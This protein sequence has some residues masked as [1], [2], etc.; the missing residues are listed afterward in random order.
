MMIL[1]LLTPMRNLI[2]TFVFWQ[3]LKIRYMASPY[4]RAAFGNVDD[5]I[6]SLTSHARCPGMIG[7]GY[8]K[9]RSF[10]QKQGQMPT[11]GE[12]S[13]RPKCVVM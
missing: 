2:S 12:A 7:A 13:A 4:S 5:R 10:M 9:L 11:A 3:M 1:E 8:G 6:L